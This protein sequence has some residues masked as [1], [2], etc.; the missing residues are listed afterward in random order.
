MYTRTGT[1]VV[2]ML[3]NLERH[4]RWTF[5]HVQ[6]SHTQGIVPK[7]RAT[8]S[9]QYHIHPRAGERLL[10]YSLTLSLPHVYPCG[11]KSDGELHDPHVNNNGLAAAASAERSP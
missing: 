6:L 2:V 3:F 1:V 4:I 9:R 8:V 11:D 5:F 7:L 10:L